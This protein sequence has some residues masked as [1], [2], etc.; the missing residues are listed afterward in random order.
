VKPFYKI[1]GFAVFCLRAWVVPAQNQVN[2]TYEHRLFT[3]GKV[4]VISMYNAVGKRKWHHKLTDTVP[5]S[6]YSLIAQRALVKPAVTTFISSNFYTQH[7]GIFCKKELQF[8]KST[9]IPL[10][11]RLGSLDYVNKLE[12]YPLA[13]FP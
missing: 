1:I 13:S 2:L 12:K 9:N 3:P 5:V 10:R 8:E 7:F 11:L 6:S 4:P